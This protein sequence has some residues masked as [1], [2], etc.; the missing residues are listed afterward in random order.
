MP[1]YPSESHV[2][3]HPFDRRSEGDSVTIGDMERQV[4]LSVPAEGVDVLDWLADGRT[5]GEAARLYEEKY[6]ESLDIEDF[7]Q[8]MELEGFL[9]PG[10]GQVVAADRGDRFGGHGSDAH[11]HDA[12]GHRHAHLLDGHLSRVS[13]RLARRFFGRTALT[14]YGILIA[15]ALV[16]V[17]LDPDLVPGSTALVFP[18]DFALLS[19]ITFVVAIGGVLVHEVAH[20]L[21]ARAVGIPATIGLG[22]QLYIPVAQTDMTGIWMAPKRARYLGFLSGAIVDAVFAALLIYV[23]WADRQGWIELSATA[24]LLLRGILFTYLARIL[25]QC[26]LF[27]RTDFYYTIATALNCN[28]LLTDTEDY[29]RN[30]LVRLR[31]SK[32]WTDQS[33]LPRHEMR[34]VRMYS[35]LWL[36]GRVTA[37]GALIVITLPLLGAYFAGVW[38]YMT[39]GET[40]FGFFDFVTAVV[41]GIGL[42]M[43]GLV[44]WARNI[45]E[46]RRQ[47][48]AR[49]RA[50]EA[51]AQ[52]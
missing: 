25:W 21:A 39:G 22:N 49:T 43:L 17:V 36:G 7:L 14:F 40:R 44:L 26:F 8:A 35:V 18:H 42:T 28:S 46:I 20:V 1:G 52:R 29:L 31:L 30:F 47:R 37:I 23:Q 3:V 32:L 15:A 45:Y 4:F 12:H 33:G 10:N 9:T 51:I 41:L 50:A 19:W 48:R 13:P 34:A 5:V 6:G 11:G 38:T 27:L 16:L 24:M 2:T